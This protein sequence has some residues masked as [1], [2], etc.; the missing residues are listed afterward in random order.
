MTI[1]GFRRNLEM[2]KNLE[3]WRELVIE[4]RKIFQNS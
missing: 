2:V 1:T 4:N 3:S